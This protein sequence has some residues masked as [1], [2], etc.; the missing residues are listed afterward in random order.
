MR[1][2]DLIYLLLNLFGICDL[3]KN[4]CH[5]LFIWIALVVVCVCICIWIPLASRYYSQFHNLAASIN[6]AAKQ[7]WIEYAGR[8]RPAHSV[9]TFWPLIMFLIVFPLYLSFSLSLSHSLSLSLQ[10]V[11]SAAISL[12]LCTA[13]FG[14]A[15]AVHCLLVSQAPV[16]QCR[17]AAVAIDQQTVGAIPLAG[18]RLHGLP[19]HLEATQP[20]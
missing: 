1:T 3:Q 19:G 10:H 14:C 9:D 4:T 13:C 20:A 12:R 6:Q 17:F 8:G 15:Q 16:K 7:L 18:Q 11:S 2:A 5:Y